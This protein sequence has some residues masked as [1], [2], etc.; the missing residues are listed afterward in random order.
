MK[1]IIQIPCYNEA[2]TLPTTLEEL[3][4][5]LTGIDQIEILV[6]D[7]G[8]NDDTAQIAKAHGAHHVV[9]LNPHQG[10]AA[11]FTNG[12]DACIHLGADLIVNT[13]AD[14]QYKADDIQSL[15]NPILDGKADIVVGDRGVA[16]L[17][18]F[19][20]SKRF[21]QQVGSWVVARASGLHIPDATS[22]FRAL[23]QEAALRTLVLS[24]YSYTL[25]TLI[26]AGNRH[27][28]VIYVPV[29]T[30]PQ[31]R[32]S[33]LIRSVPQYLAY[34]GSTIVRAY[35]MYRPLR[36]F[37][38]LASLMILGALILTFRYFYF[39]SI[40]QGQGHVQSVILAAVLF[41][42]GFQTLLIGLVADLVGFNR[43][44][45]EETLYRMRK[46]ETKQVETPPS[47]YINRG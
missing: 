16:N 39:V 4:R 34:S 43:M 25:E 45:M 41:I 26:Q 29:R 23:S 42:V 8:S 22:G 21:L 37:S 12:L 19:S 7:D 46:I 13:D 31:T 18:S 17:D 44:I 6:I 11:S 35:A 2:E 30:N 33:R 3:P 28:A 47:S 14:N 15:I 10:L 9:R 24:D 5:Q 36:I 20:A 38:I 27:L 40:G 1:L 32:P